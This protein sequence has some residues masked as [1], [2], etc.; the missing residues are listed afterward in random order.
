M[1]KEGLISI[2][3]PS[4]NRAEVIGKS[5][6]SVLQQSYSNLE[7]IV[8]DDGSSDNTKEVVEAIQDDRVKYVYQ[9]N[10]GACAARNNGFAHAKGEFIALNDSD[11]VWHTDKLKRQIDLLKSED[12]DVVCCRLAIIRNQ[13][14][15]LLPKRIKDRCV[16]KSDDFF[17]IGTQTLL[18]KRTVLESEVFDDNIPRLQDLEWLMRVLGKFKVYCIG[19]GLVDYSIN[20]DSITK[21]AKKLY[22]ALHII[23]EKHPN[24]TKDYCQIAMHSIKDLIQNKEEILKAGISQQEYKK[25]FKSWMPNVFKYVYYYIK[26]A[27]I[28]NR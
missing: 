17:G 14:P 11:D 25:L 21:D 19:D 8:V 16:L 1:A 28:L 13:K 4:Y 27:W 22:D 15:I 2:I 20:S 12:V 3:I 23:R 26:N 24:V 10:Q 18:M 9:N 7:I 5:I 6:Q